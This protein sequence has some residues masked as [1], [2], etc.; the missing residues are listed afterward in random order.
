M[1]MTSGTRSIASPLHQGLDALQEALDEV[2][3]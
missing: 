3:R 2:S 1:E